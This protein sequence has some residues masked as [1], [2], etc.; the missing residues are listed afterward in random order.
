MTRL[1]KRSRL[2][3]RSSEP[4]SPERAYLYALRILNARDYTVAR[5]REKL[6]GRGFDDADVEAVL[7]R[8]VSE[9]WVDDR[10]FAERFAESAV[11]SGRYYGPR[12]RQE[13]RRRGVQPE[14]VSEVLGRILLERD[15]AEEV[16]A[17]VERRFSGFS[18]STASDREKCRTIGFLQRRGFSLS[19]VLRALRATEQY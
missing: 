15:E 3:L 14:L 10:R 1:W 2:P 6:H 19:A 18:F 4:S 5:L 17:I 9:G 7:G 11:A 13:M 16:R 8:M 12:L